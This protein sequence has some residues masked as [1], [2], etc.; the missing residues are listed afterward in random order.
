MN[1]E[2]SMPLWTKIATG[3]L[4]VSFVTLFLKKPTFFYDK[5]NLN[6][7]LFALSFLAFIIALWRK[8]LQLALPRS[9]WIGLA[10]SFGFLFLATILSIHT[11]H[12]LA[13]NALREYARIVAAFAICIETYVLAREFPAILR[14]M[15][16]ALA[17]SLLLLPA[18]IYAPSWA[19]AFF[20]DDSSTRFT[21]FLA[22]PNYYAAFEVVPA[23]LA[24]W[25]VF[26]HPFKKNHLVSIIALI[27]FMLATGSILWSGSRGGIA[28][29]IAGIIVYVALMIWKLPW[30]TTLARTGILLV[31][32][33]LSFFILPAQARY[34]ITYRADTIVNT[35]SDAPIF[36]L[37]ARQGRSAIWKSALSQIA[38]NPLGYGPDY[39]PT[40]DIQGDN[41]DHHRVAHNTILQI[42]LT[43]GVGLFAIAIA[44]AWIFVRLIFTMR[45]PFGMAE[46]AI[47]A[48][49]ATLVAALFL[50]SLWSRWI[51]VLIA[52][53]LALALRKNT[54]ATN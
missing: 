36:N 4:L 48:L 22:D 47:G 3:L 8:E 33:G 45:L 21:G 43:G 10:C 18:M 20:L 6:D 52:I 54:T 28:G 42:L 16:Y 25:F 13:P 51:W 26:E 9:I 37:T 17:A 5:T 15:L 32:C 29:L 19:H 11:H 30:R 24:L 39:G 41:N 40:A 27:L 23:L 2:P 7:A 38:R 1:N 44:G 31:A 46:Y 14:L 53:L 12:A 49:A 34:D 50:D 35:G